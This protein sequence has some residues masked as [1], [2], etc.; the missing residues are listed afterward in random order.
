VL[1]DE[2]PGVNCLADRE[3]RLRAGRK[4]VESAGEVLFGGDGGLVDEKSNTELKK[5]PVRGLG[6][7]GDL[8]KQRLEERVEAVL[9]YLF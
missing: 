7:E 9:A 6:G 3:P 2:P 1:A 5:S 4:S 8:V